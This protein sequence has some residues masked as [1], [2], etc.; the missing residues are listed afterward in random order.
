MGVSSSFAPSTQR[1]I[2]SCGPCRSTAAAKPTPFLK[3]AFGVSNGQFSPDGRWVA[4]ASNESGKWEIDVAP[5]PGPGGNWK[6]STAGGSEPR[7]RRDGKELFY[8]APDGKMMAVDV[9]AGST[10][11][12]GVARP[13]FQVAGGSPYPPRTCSATT[14]PPTVS[15]SWS[16]PIRAR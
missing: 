8:L 14:S 12:A 1:V 9:K 10:F 7:W 16:I 11:E 6:V 3:T 15:A 2:S 13:L 4:Y 5:F